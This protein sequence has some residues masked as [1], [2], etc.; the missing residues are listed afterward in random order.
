MNYKRVS[1]YSSSWWHSLLMSLQTSGHDWLGVPTVSC[2]GREPDD[3]FRGLLLSGCDI[4]HAAKFQMKVINSKSD[5]E[6]DP[7]PSIK[8][9]ATNLTQQSKDKCMVVQP[10]QNNGGSYGPRGGAQA[11]LGN[12]E[13]SSAEW[14]F[15]D[16][17]G[18]IKSHF[19]GSGQREVC[20]TTGWPFLQVGAFDTPNGEMRKAT[21]IL[22][23]AAEPAN[24]VLRNDG[25]V[26]ITN[27]IPAHSVQ[28]ILYD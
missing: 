4:N 22:N 16:L 10:L 6:S 5:I 25:E 14:K 21:I 12:C 24:Y 13:D 27:S 2:I 1:T 28:T 8:F 19:F 11:T 18:E 17:T 20:L 7:S 23:E 3:S 15:D 9:I 26:F